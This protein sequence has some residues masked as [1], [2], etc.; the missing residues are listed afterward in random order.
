MQQ[1]SEAIPVASKGKW[2]ISVELA[3]FVFGSSK[4][5]AVLMK[6]AW[7]LVTGILSAAV[8]APGSISRALLLSVLIYVVLVALE[9]RRGSYVLEIK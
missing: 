8:A 3:G 9:V 2:E 1:V 4:W 7:V 5:R 6:H